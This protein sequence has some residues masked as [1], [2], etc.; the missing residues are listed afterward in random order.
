MHSQKYLVEF[1]FFFVGQKIKIVLWEKPQGTLGL[2][3]RI[4]IFCPDK[5]IFTEAQT[6]KWHNFRL[7]RTCH[8]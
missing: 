6:G 2:K 4:T 3:E 5:H 7:T 8:K 1:S